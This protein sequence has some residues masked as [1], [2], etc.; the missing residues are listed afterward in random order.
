M[1]PDARTELSE[2]DSESL[3][4]SLPIIFRRQ[5]RFLG[6]AVLVSEF[7]EGPPLVDFF[8]A[9]YETLPS[10]IRKRLFFQLGGIVV[11]DQMSGNSDRIIASCIRGYSNFGN[12]M[13]E[14]PP[15]NPTL[16]LIDNGLSDERA[17]RGSLRKFFSSPEDFCETMLT[18][19]FSCMTDFFTEDSVFIQAKRLKILDD[20]NF[21]PRA[22]RTAK[23][24]IEVDFELPE[25]IECFKAGVHIAY[26]RLKNHFPLEAVTDAFA[27]ELLRSFRE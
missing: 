3:F 4:N 8:V 22:L 16:V 5:L 26:D 9:G 24:P 27:R 25:Y 20:P 23:L 11:L 1:S 12:L 10:A 18:R 17:L 14:G 13:I 21:D 7:V 6:P 15:E 19:A 2:E